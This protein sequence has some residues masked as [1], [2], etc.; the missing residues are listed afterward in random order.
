MTLKHFRL[1]ALATYY[2]LPA[3][4][5]H[6]MHWLLCRDSQR[7]HRRFNERAIN[8]QSCHAWS[9]QRRRWSRRFTGH[10]VKGLMRKVRSRWNR[11]IELE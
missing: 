1:A 2:V 11:F 9:W 3:Y 4:S 8:L 7:W 10:E 5:W 6:L